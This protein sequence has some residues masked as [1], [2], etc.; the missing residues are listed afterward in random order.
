MT[1]NLEMV[2]L[3]ITVCFHISIHMLHYVI[4][5]DDAH[6]KCINTNFRKICALYRGRFYII[7]YSAFF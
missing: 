2:G 7:V 6:I 4:K 5:N 1:H 3:C